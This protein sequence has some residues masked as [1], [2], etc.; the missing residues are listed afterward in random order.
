M[1]DYG[2][3]IIKLNQKGKSEREISELLDVPKTTVHKII[4]K[5]NETG[6][7]DRRR[8][9]GRPRT[10]RTPANKRKIK[11]RIQRNPSSRKNSKRKMAAV[12][13]IGRESVG[14]ILHKD[15][16]MKSRKEAEG[17]NLEDGKDALG[18]FFIFFMTFPFFR[19]LRRFGGGRHRLIMFSDEAW[20]DIEQAHN[21]QNDRNCS[22]QPLPLND[23]IIP[24][25]QHP[26]QVMVWA[27]VG[28]G[29][30]TPLFFVP[31]GVSINGE[32]YREFS[33]TEV[34]PWARRH[35]G[36]RHW[37]FMQDPAPA[38]KAI[39]TQNLIRANVPEFIEVD[40]SPQRN[41]GE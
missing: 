17:Q 10:A 35:Y 7:T 39:E 4:V 26:K 29:V 3:A 21:T 22:E 31:A 20:Y 34:F 32:V 19:L 5:Y 23:R 25:Q 30:K 27:G 37:V 41:N 24:R 36:N 18:K 12:L 40:I 1:A 2:K 28:H 13:G 11:E 9:S 15:L 33:R 16:G 38:H 14:N 6:T 8:G